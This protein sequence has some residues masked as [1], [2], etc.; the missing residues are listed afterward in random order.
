MVS[1]MQMSDP[2]LLKFI[3]VNI[4]HTTHSISLDYFCD[5]TYS[6][7]IKQFNPRKSGKLHTFERRLL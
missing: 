5:K 1:F 3:A 6:Y 7:I 2:H 4:K